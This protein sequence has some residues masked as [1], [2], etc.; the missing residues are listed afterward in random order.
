MNENSINKKSNKREIHR[1]ARLIHIVFH[2]WSITILHICFIVDQEFHRTVLCYT[3]HTT[4]LDIPRHSTVSHGCTK[5]SNIVC[6]C[7]D[8]ACASRYFHAEILCTSKGILR[9][10]SL[11]RSTHHHSRSLF[12]SSKT[13]VTII[14]TFKFFLVSNLTLTSDLEHDLKEQTN[15]ICA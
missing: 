11:L 3:S 8:V 5:C 12:N 14:Y 2:A 7:V 4:Q 9:V 10:P 13:C 15:K 6:M 1:V